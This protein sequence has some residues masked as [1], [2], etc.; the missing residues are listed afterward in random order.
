MGPESRDNMIMS[1]ALLAAIAV[2]AIVRQMLALEK[3][4]HDFAGNARLALLI[5]LYF[6]HSTF[7]RCH[8]WQ[9]L[10]ALWFVA[11]VGPYSELWATWKEYEKHVAGAVST[12]EYAA[13]WLECFAF[14]LVA[15]PTLPFMASVAQM[16]RHVFSLML[17]GIS[18]NFSNPPL[19]NQHIQ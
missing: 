3:G 8:M 17:A 2:T 18:A 9:R 11:T 5:P 15:T 19:D 16:P 14:Y 12:E 10:A 6:S 4:Q 1:V 7:R 13:I